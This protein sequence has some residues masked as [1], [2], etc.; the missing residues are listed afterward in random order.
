M[1]SEYKF[2]VKDGRRIQGRE[3]VCIFCR[4]VVFGIYYY[5]FKG[6]VRYINSCVKGVDV[7]RQGQDE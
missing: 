1:R 2:L 7:I 6:Q 3:K 4:F 5:F